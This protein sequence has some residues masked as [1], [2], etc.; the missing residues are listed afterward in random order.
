M[1]GSVVRRA[2]FG[3]SRVLVATGPI[4]LLL[5][6][7]CGGSGPSAPEITNYAGT[8]SGDWTQSIALGC[9]CVSD[10][11]LGLSNGSS[12]SHTMTLSQAG[13]AV[14]GTWIS[15]ETGKGC[16]VMGTVDIDLDFVEGDLSGC[17][18][19][20]QTGLECPNGRRRDLLQFGGY[21]QSRVDGDTLVGS[22]DEFFQ[23]FDS[24]TG[25]QI[26]TVRLEGRFSLSRR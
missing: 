1:E 2:L 26:G 21:W 12:E 23:C 14:Q 13:A 20:L 25:K 10:D 8:W 18:P 9:G 4:L 15:A 3:F 11:L 17:Q 19:E 16:E 5:L 22:L 24:N 6:S 7:A